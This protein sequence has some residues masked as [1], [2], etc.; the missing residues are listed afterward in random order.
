MATRR[1]TLT[2]PATLPKGLRDPWINT[3]ES[4]LINGVQVFK[5]ENEE[6]G[7]IKWV[8]LGLHPED[9]EPTLT[10]Q[11]NEY[12]EQTNEVEET[13]ADRVMTLLQSAKGEGR[14]E[15]N[16]YRVVNGERQY[17]SKYK[18]EE[19]E[20]GTFEMLRS[21]FGSGEYELRLYATD[22]RTGRF[23]IRSQTR[24]KIA[25]SK[26]PT[27]SDAL[28]SGLSQVLTTIAQGQEQMLRALVEM[29]Q[30][31]QKDPMEE[32]TK[33]LSMMTLM[34]EA[35]GITNQSREKSSIREIVDAVKEL[36]G[37]AEEFTPKEKE[38]DSLMGML[39][40]VLEMVSA[41]QTQQQIQPAFIPPVTM[42]QSVQAQ[43]QQTQ[44]GEDV[45]LMTMIKLKGYLKS[46]CDM[47]KTDKSI[48]EGANYVYENLPDDL[49]EIMML[50][51][52][53]DLLSGVAPEVKPH[54]E[55]LK[56]VR[57][58][59]IDMFGDPEEHTQPKI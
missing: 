3:Q 9:D 2:T 33:M 6:I 5:W 10:A 35:M 31:P 45:N 46:L 58:M 15:L 37:A 17:C 12:S 18:P 22:P 28:P 36:K 54:E 55:W 43:P 51:N 24:V 49:I 8:G 57:N 1:K 11:V 4:A 39:P 7:E 38:E 47:A 26:T 14:A 13:P 50:D 48:S 25:E 27:Q 40:K 53:F 44:Q 29:K 41:G 32:M 21:N 20:E 30:A 16:V 56:N 23:V 19:F 34:R 52:W 42:P 59:A